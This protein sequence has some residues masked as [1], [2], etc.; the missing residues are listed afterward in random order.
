MDLG[1]HPPR[2]GKHALNPWSDF[3][4]S[5]QFVSE[6]FGLM[7]PGMPQT[8]ARLGLHYTHVTIGGE[9]SQTTQLF[10]TMIATA[11]FTADMNRILDAGLASLDPQ[12][13]IRRIITDVFDVPTVLVKRR[14][15]APYGDAI[16]AG[17]AS[18]LFQDFSVARQ[19]TQYIEPMEPDP[20]KHAIYME[21][22]GLYKDLYDHIRNDY[23]TLAALREKYHASRPARQ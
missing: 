4:I 3:N 9:P 18:G 10:T 13:V 7:S 17:V 19:W 16:L 12:S 5:G 21:Y 14:T 15:G 8:A 2:T 20:K 1:I 6:S 23:R 11:F 22:F